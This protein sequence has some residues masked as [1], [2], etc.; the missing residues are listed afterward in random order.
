MSLRLELYLQGRNWIKVGELLPGMRPGSIFYNRP[1]GRRDVY[2]F[3]CERDNSKSVIYRST[4]GLDLEVDTIR[5]LHTQGLEVVKELTALQ[6][7]YELEVRTYKN[8]TFKRI[9]FTHI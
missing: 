3:E 1:D 6:P 4:C 8:Q 2:V 9:R 5:A 7:S